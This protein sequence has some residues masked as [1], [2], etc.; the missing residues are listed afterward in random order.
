[1]INYTFLTVQNPWWSK[2]EAIDLD[3]KI[4]EFEASSVQYLPLNI[5]DQSLKDAAVN[6]V[7]GPRQVGKSTAIKLLI[8]RLLKETQASNILYFNCDCLDSRKDII[9]LV[10]TFL[11]G[12]KTESVRLPANYLFLDEISSVDDW[13]YA[14]KWLADSGFLSSSKIILTGSSSISLKK[15][16]EFLPGRRGSG[17]DITFLPLKFFDCF[18]LLYPGVF[19]SP[20]SSFDDLKQAKRKASIKEIDLKKNYERFLLTGGFLKMLDTTVKKEPY[21]GIIDLY[22]DTLRSELAKYRKKETHA[23]LILAK[24]IASLGSETSYAN[25]AEEAELGSKNTA[26]EYLRFFS[27]SFFLI[28][29]LFYSIPERRP[30]LKKNKKYY[31]SDPFLFW[32]FNSFISGGSEIDGFYQRYLQAPLNSRMAEAFIATELYKQGFEFYYS[33]NGKEIDFYLPKEELAIEVKYKNKI[34]TQDMHGLKYGK[35]KIVVSNNT[36]EKKGD[37]LIVPISLFGFIDLNFFEK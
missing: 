29:T 33:R 21:A 11:D 24:I 5:L 9:E 4:R 35:R 28:E 14:I 16:G 15:N 26:A 18:N 6:I 17:K 1:M 30:V 8:K 12:I 36:L 19:T 22:K 20:L 3:A 23:R 10:V 2:K 27:D 13:P 25:I 31:P 32:I 34:T 37:I 7:Y